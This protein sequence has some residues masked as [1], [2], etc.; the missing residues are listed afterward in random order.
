MKLNL[1]LTTYYKGTPIEGVAN[2]L[3]DYID[4]ADKEESDINII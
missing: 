4:N 1:V 2:V 3:E